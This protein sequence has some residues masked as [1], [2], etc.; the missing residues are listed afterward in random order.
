MSRI[1]VY[2]DE[3]VPASL[4]GYLTGHDITVT[5]VQ[6]EQTQG[7]SD[8]AQLRYAAS[9]GLI[10]LTTNVRHFHRWHHEFLARGL[11]HGGIITV[12]Q[13]D[14]M[15]QRL[16]I[17]SALLIEWAETFMTT[18]NMLFHWT[19]LQTQLYT[20]YIPRGYSA[21]EINLALG[22]GAAEAE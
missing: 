5:T 2:L 14:R 4:S 11:Q 6:A 9:A 20:G 19:D 21:D 17:R 18:R 12:P 15:P 22:R 3:N 7:L 10:L 13:D 8:D 1:R 16:Y